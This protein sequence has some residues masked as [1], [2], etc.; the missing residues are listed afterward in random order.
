MPGTPMKHRVLA[1]LQARATRECGEN[2]TIADYA[3]SFVAGGG[4]MRELAELLAS[5]LGHPVS[6]SFVSGTINRLAK[7]TKLRLEAARRDA[8]PR[9]KQAAAVLLVA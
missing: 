7:D 1:A 5:D 3:C 6:R 2:A 9:L 8:R 4:C